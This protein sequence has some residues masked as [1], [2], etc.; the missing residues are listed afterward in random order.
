[1]YG[2]WSVTASLV[3]ANVPDMFSPLVYEIWMLEQT[4]TVVTLSNPTT[5][6][7]ATISVDKVDGNTASFHRTQYAPGR[8]QRIGEN[9]VLTVMEN[10]MNGYSYNKL[11]YLK[12]GQVTKGFYAKYAIQAERINNG[13]VRFGSPEPPPMEFEI[14][15]VRREPG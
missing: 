13:R 12:N 5:G 1:M 14:E 7:S 15:K 9:P 4:G 6:A 2:Q 11:E 8:M 10:V 3:E